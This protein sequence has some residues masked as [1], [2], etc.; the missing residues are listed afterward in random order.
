MSNRSSKQ[1]RRVRVDRQATKGA[2]PPGPAPVDAPPECDCPQLDF[3]D[4][5]E[6]ESDWSD[7]QFLKAALPA[8][9]GVPI[10]YAGMRQKLAAEAAKLG[11]TVPDSPMVLLGEGR[12]RRPVLLEVETG[13]PHARVVQPGGV[14]WSRIVPAHFGDMKRLAAETRDMARARYGRDPGALWVWYLTCAVCSEARNWETMFVAHYAS[15]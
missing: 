5:H 4:W 3:D 12:L 1:R 9:A 13:A 7:I 10:G 15:P 14:A 8:V 11:L 2:A 6:V